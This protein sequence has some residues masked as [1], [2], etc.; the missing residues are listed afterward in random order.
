M[1]FSPDTATLPARNL[2][3]PDALS[4]G[5]SGRISPAGYVRRG[6]AAQVD[7]RDAPPGCAVAFALA[8][9]VRATR[10]AVAD[11]A[12]QPVRFV[13]P[14]KIAGHETVTLRAAG[15][16]PVAASFVPPLNGTAVIVGHGTPGSRADLWS[17]VEILA[18]VGFGVLALDWP[19]HGET[20]GR[21][22]LG[23]PER[24]AFRAA[25]DF[26][27]SRDDVKHIGAYGFSNG[28]SLVVMGAADDPR[29]RA[30]LAVNA[31][32]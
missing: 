6:E 25:V 7:P 4:F 22:R 8:Q 2:S 31:L 15:C 27:A 18:R 26:L 20:G 10:D 23:T 5:I 3:A 12:P 30:V 32:G 1:E 29:V 16:E 19:G 17:D 9:A 13:P 21:M 24:D 11:F 28:G 14:S